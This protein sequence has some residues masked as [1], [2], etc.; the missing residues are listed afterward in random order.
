MGGACGSSQETAVW[1]PRRCRFLL[2]PNI[3]S[4]YILP[5]LIPH[6]TG[7]GPEHSLRRRIDRC[8]RAAAAGQLCQFA[9][10]VVL[11]GTAQ[12]FGAKTMVIIR[13]SICGACSILA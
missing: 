12:C 5:R 11:G 2:A 13:P 9:G 8:N 4:S 1:R 3:R 6:Q 7:G 10:M